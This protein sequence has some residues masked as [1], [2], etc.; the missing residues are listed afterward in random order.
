VVLG[1]AKVISYEDLA[2]ARAERGAKDAAKLKGTRKRGRKHKSAAPEADASEPKVRVARTSR[3]L[4]TASMF[5]D[6]NEGSSG[7]SS[8]GDDIKSP[9]EELSEIR[10]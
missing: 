5:N 8:N 10:P 7:C 2:K 6:A 3:V 1:K 4:E 9:H